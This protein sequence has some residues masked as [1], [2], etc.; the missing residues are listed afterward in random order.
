MSHLPTDTNVRDRA[1]INGRKVGSRGFG[2]SACFSAA[3]TF[4]A[5][6]ISSYLIVCIGWCDGQ[7]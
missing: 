2:I 1:A 5:G 4:S 3:G 7:E 6:M